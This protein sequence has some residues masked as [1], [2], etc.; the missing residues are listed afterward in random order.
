MDGY[1]IYEKGHFSVADSSWKGSFVLLNFLGKH[2][3]TTTTTNSDYECAGRVRLGCF[4]FSGGLFWYTCERYQKS[5]R[6]AFFQKKK[7]TP[8]PKLGVG[9]WV[10]LIGLGFHQGQPKFGGNGFVPRVLGWAGSG[11]AE[12]QP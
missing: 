12:V 3:T 4:F 2:P 11:R 6:R 5:K 8:N 10:K 7:K 9:T 1:Q